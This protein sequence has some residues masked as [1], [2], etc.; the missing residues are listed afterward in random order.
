[1]ASARL[2][3]LFT[4]AACAQPGGDAP[5]GPP[6]VPA[7]LLPSTASAAAAAA[8]AGAAAAAALAAAGPGPEAL[9]AAVA[10]GDLAAALGLPPVALDGAGRAVWPV[11]LPALSRAFRLAALAVHPDRCAHPDAKQ[12]FAALSDAHAELADPARRAAWLRGRRGALLDDLRASDPAAAARVAA[13]AEAADRA[14]FAGGVVAATGRMAG[15]CGAMG[16]VW[17]SS[18]DF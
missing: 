2:G 3:R 14:A 7:H 5:R 6:A 18:G 1:M 11:G 17:C 4:A 9:L 16:G 12:A 13:A 8:P 10:R 15:R